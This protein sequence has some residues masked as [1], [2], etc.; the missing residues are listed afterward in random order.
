VSDE[1]KSSL[2]ASINLIAPNP[3]SSM[4]PSKERGRGFNRF[5]LFFPKTPFSLPQFK[6][7]LLVW[8]PQ[9]LSFPSFYHLAG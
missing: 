8:H 4:W 7:F 2:F 1:K 3:F 5:M 9:K 6:A